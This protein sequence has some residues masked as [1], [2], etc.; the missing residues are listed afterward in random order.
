MFNTVRHTL[1]FP[2]VLLLIL[3]NT[4]SLLAQDSIRKPVLVGLGIETYFTMSGH[5]GFYSAFLAIN[6]GKGTF[7]AGPVMHKRSQQITGAKMSYSYRI[8]TMNGEDVYNIPFNEFRVG[9]MQVNL[10]A[11]L[12]YVQNTGL[13]YKRAVETQLLNIDSATVNT[14]WNGTRLN[15]VEGGIGVELGIKITKRVLWTS[16]IGLSVYDHL[17]YFPELYYEKAAVVLMVGTGLSIPTFRLKR[18]H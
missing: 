9:S 11:F 3:L 7:K 13:S 12:H 15:T 5:G 14:N 16:Y 18:K 10:F 6:K 2:A 17:N 4:N 8:A 1:F